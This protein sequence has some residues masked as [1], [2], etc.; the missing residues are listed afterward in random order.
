MSDPQ[1]PPDEYL[2]V[3]STG[4]RNAIIFTLI[5][6]VPIVAFVLFWMLR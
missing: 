3:G 5:A 6:L 4:S 2:P 1:R